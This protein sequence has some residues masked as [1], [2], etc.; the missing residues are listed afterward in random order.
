[1]TRAKAAFFQAL[2]M[3][4]PFLLAGGALLAAGA[5]LPVQG[6]ARHEPGT[7]AY[8]ARLQL[9]LSQKTTDAR[10]VKANRQ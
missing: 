9:E 5:Q 7:L 4:V 2:R 1:M 6:E 8:S 10:S 3:T